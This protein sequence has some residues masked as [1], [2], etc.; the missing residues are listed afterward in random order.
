M[1]RYTIARENRVRNKYTQNIAHAVI[2][3]AYLLASSD[4]LLLGI[5]WFAPSMDAVGCVKTTCCCVDSCAGCGCPKSARSSAQATV[6][7]PSES[8][9]E[10]ES[11]T[12]LLPIDCFADAG[13][14]TLSRVGVG[15]RCGALDASTNFATRD[16]KH[17]LTNTRLAAQRTP[18]PPAKI[19]IT[20]LLAFTL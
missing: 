14:K 17:R 20:T 7:S 3:G 8:T 13:E 10:T 4:A 16:T 6:S 2:L 12:S 1:A 19:P 5:R 18:L 11:E 9:T 15:G